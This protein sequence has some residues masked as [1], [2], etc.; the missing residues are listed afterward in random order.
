M[1]RNVLPSGSARNTA[2]DRAVEE[3]SRALDDPLQHA[4]QLEGRRDLPADLGELG[5]LRARRWD[6][7]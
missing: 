3:L 1:A 2:L 5:H 6:S 7:R 4:P